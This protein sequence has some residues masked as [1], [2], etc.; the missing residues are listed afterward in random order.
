MP[1]TWIFH[2]IFRA[3]FIISLFSASDLVRAETSERPEKRERNT[4]FCYRSFNPELKTMKTF[5][6]LGVN[7][8]CFFPGN[9]LNSLGQPYS[10]Y[11]P[12]WLGPNHYD[13]ASLDR[14]IEDI[15]SANPE[16]KLLCMIDLNTPPWM[17]RRFAFDSFSE[18]SVA[19]CNPAWRAETTKFLE[20]FI[21][22]AE[23]KHADRVAG[24]ILSG[25]GTS[26][27][28][29]YNRG[30][31]SR[32]KNNAWREWCKR[33]GMPTE[34]D[35]P[36]VRE[37][38]QGDFEGFLYDP[39]TQPHV[40]RYWKFH[41]EIIVDAM[42]E[43]AQNA[44]KLIPSERELGYFFG[45]IFVA[46][47]NEVGTFGHLDYE[48]LYAV[49]EVD[50][51]ISPG[52]YA[53]RMMGGGS[54]PQLMLGT[55]KRH[56]KRYMHETDHRTSTTNQGVGLK[57]NSQAA[58]NAL[59]KREACFAL[60]NHSSMWWFDMWGG[61][62]TVP[63]TL[64]L[65]KRIR[66][67]WDRFRDDRSGS[68]AEVLLIADP[69]SALHLAERHPD[70]GKVFNGTQN[71]LNRLGAPYDAYSFNDIPSLDMSRYKLVVFP[72]T[73]EITPQR[74]EILE[75]H[76]LK[77]NR[78]V[79]WNYAPGILD[80]EKLDIDN[81]QKWTGVKYG[82]PGVNKLV[83]DGWT[84]V[85]AHSYDETTPDV[86]KTVAVEAGVTLYCESKNPVFANARLFSVHTV[87][88]GPQKITLP[89]K[90]RRVVDVFDEKTIAENVTEFIYEFKKP[91]T[92]LF[93]TVWEE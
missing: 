47:P 56:G 42:I 38:D 72:G 74:K 23:A 31:G 50:F 24:Y 17:T 65:I 61:Y 44:R 82:S 9:T 29:E 77:D 30:R 26:E 27:W 53:D 7:T 55:L 73:F 66:E 18:I 83:R 45:Y 86:L 35:P 25:G 28:Y 70:S 89:R 68:I 78:T 54:G 41:N 71:K 87:E 20:A 92:V 39:V 62:Y 36:T 79:F 14:Q 11:P 51:F 13:F 81:V 4:Y 33:N 76:V 69:Q 15:L 12:L 88:G 59:L 57:S 10:Q 85:Y 21:K 22:H 67:V 16:A 84:S 6:E 48:R 32:G 60:I 37:L 52:N 5:H 80:G 2:R 91:D 8:I 19:A 40:A 46:G 1:T 75:K 58:D 93:E 63:E 3:I 43:F 34:D 49:S 90:C 64:D